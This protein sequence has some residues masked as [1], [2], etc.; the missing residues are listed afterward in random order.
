MAQFALSSWSVHG[1]LGKAR[2]NHNSGQPVLDSGQAQGSIPLL[3]LPALMA[4]HGIQI[5][6]I[7]HFHLPSI[8]DAYLAQ[9]RQTLADNDVTLLNILI[10]MGNLSSANEA[11][12]QTDIDLAK[13]WQQITAQLGGVGNR[14]DCGKAEPTADAVGRSVDA[15]A[16]LIDHAASLG[17]RVVTENFH[18]TSRQPDVL[19]DIMQRVGRPIGLCVDF[20]NAEYSAEKF[21]ILEKLMP[22][23]TSIH[24]KANYHNGKIDLDDLHRCLGIMQTA[25]FDGPISLIYNETENEWPRIIELQQ[26][27]ADY[28]VR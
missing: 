4:K 7:C 23:A 1:L 19:I 25:D 12:R 8:E 3:E 13:Q 5:L 10:D 27:I 24:C 15:L 6:E 26:A 28:L 22:Y 16:E 11:E 2:F 9:L 21:T 14:I 17:V 20:G 18:P